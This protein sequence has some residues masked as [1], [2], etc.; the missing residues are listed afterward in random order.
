[1]QQDAERQR[2]RRTTALYRLTQELSSA[3]NFPELL[4]IA[5]RE[6]SA[7]FEADVAV[8]LP[9]PEPEAR[10]L[11][12]PYPAG[13]WQLDEQEE[14]VAAWAFQHDQPAGRFTDTLPQAA[15]L[16]LPLSAGAKPS[17]VIALRFR[18]DQP[19]T[20]QQ[21][22]L[23]E[24]FV[25]QIALVIDRQRLRERP[26]RGRKLLGGIRTPRED[27]VEFRLP[28]IAY[29]AGRH[30]GCGGGFARPGAQGQSCPEARA[31]GRIA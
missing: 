11:L 8:M 14:G 6:V 9:D 29:A 17:G 26:T 24:S 30:H 22:N 13:L 18:S 28:R 10:Q 4:S 19:P 23:L 1:M 3:N 20:L 16:H 5:I 12:S 2:E 27:T 15:A 21:R 7:A 31:H 25:R